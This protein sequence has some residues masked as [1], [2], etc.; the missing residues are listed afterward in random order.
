MPDVHP[1]AIL[2]G[3][4]D[5]ADD[6]RIG[7]HCVL[8]GP[9][10][11][12]AGTRL[13]GSVFVEGPATIGSGNTVYPF[14]C[15]GF[16]PQHAKY[17]PAEPGE[18]TVIGDGNTFRESVTVHRAFTDHG[19]TRIGDGNMFMVNTHVGHDTVV[20]SDVT[21][22]NGSLLGG[23]VTLGDRVIVGGNSSV[24]QFV[25]VARGAM[26]AGLSGPTLDVPPFFMVTGI[27]VCPAPN[28]VGARRSGMSREDIEDVRWVY[29]LLYRRGLSRNGALEAIRERAD[30]PLVAEYIQFIESS[31]RG[32][33]S[34]RAR[35]VRGT[36][37]SSS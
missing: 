9:V 6:V 36:T 18:G 2:D 27:N 11:I 19:P 8:T 22:V 31:E 34:A 5:L 29:R 37:V 25:R 10:T 35:P 3:D 4:V 13:V 23:H 32:I 21:M 24:H 28:L 33:V 7:P 12:G 30:R 26:I 1:T 14:T 20:G 17:D 16:S 15:L